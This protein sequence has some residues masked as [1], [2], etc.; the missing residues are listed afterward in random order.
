M[1]KLFYSPSDEIR[2]LD[3]NFELKTTK[4]IHKIH[5]IDFKANKYNFEYNNK[6]IYYK[7]LADELQPA[8]FSLYRE[9]LN[10][11]VGNYIINKKSFESKLITMINDT[12]QIGN[13]L[14]MPVSKGFTFSPLRPVILGYFNSLDEL[15]MNSSV[16]IVQLVGPWEIIDDDL[17]LYFELEDILTNVRNCVTKTI[18]ILVDFGEK[19]SYKNIKLNTNNDKTEYLLLNANKINDFTKINNFIKSIDDVVINEMSTFNKQSC[20]FELTALPLLMFVTN[21]LIKKIKNNLY[22]TLNETRLYGSSMQFLYILALMFKSTNVIINDIITNKFGYVKY[23]TIIDDQHTN[24]LIKELDNVTNNYV[25]L[26]EYLGQN[27]AINISNV[28][29][30][31]N[32]NTNIRK[33]NIDFLI[34]SIINDHVDPEFIELIIKSYKIKRKLVK[35]QL[36]RINYLEN[37]G[38]RLDINSIL[39]NNVQKSIDY[40]NEHNIEINDV[41]KFF[42]V[43][44]YKTIVKTYFPLNKSLDFKDIEISIDSIYSITKPETVNEMSNIIKKYFKNVDYIIDGN[45]NVGTTSIGFSEKFKHVYA[46]EYMHTTYDKLVHNI[47]LYKLQ[48]VTI[49]HD[50]LIEFMKNNDK[51]NKI[52]F[53]IEKYCL[54]LDPPWSGV[55]Y[56]LQKQLDLSLSDIDILDFIKDIKI[57]YVCIKAPNNYNFAKLHTYFNN[58]VV[59]RLSGFYF[60]L[61]TK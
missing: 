2:G 47:K 36:E 14:L 42:T 4:N 1:N 18:F 49:F 15:P 56:K 26:D 21:S 52:K 12:V 57:R 13:Y 16:C 31:D 55:F 59:H 35:K 10:Y 20:Q 32:L 30:C 29:Y 6:N 60:I 44:N 40:C 28:K 9:F 3:I 61:I 25:K 24:K 7:F 46:I 8:T 37:K 45:A 39:A 34:K 22:I 11:T 51:L 19:I 50:D 48:N 5:N 58:I 38:D 27:T 54:F 33:P 53:D 17:N 41:Y 23:E 43:L